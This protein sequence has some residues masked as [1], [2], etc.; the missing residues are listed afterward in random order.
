MFTFGG[1]AT[2]IQARVVREDGT[3]IE[4]LYAVGSSAACVPQRT[5]FVVPAIDFTVQHRETLLRMRVK[6][7]PRSFLYSP[8]SKLAATS[9]E[10]AKTVAR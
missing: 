7:A 5:T 3:A 10:I 8:A 4:G 9:A 1:L 2:D 6:V